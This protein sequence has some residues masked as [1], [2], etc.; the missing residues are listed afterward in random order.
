MGETSPASWAF[1][2]VPTLPRI[3]PGAL[4]AGRRRRPERAFLSLS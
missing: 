1:P 4:R 3:L 2:L